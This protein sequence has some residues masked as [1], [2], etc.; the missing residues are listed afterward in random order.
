MEASMVIAGMTEIIVERSWKP[1][2]VL[3]LIWSNVNKSHSEI[4]LDDN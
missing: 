4:E 3:F 1:C 2:I